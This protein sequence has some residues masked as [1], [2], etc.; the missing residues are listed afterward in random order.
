MTLD[1]SWES[2]TIYFT[3]EKK[4]RLVYFKIF[5]QVRFVE[6]KE[7][8]S[9]FLSSDTISTYSFKCMNHSNSVKICFIYQ[10][11]QDFVFRIRGLCWGVWIGFTI[12]DLLSRGES[13]RHLAF[14]CTACVDVIKGQINTL[15]NGNMNKTLTNH[16]SNLS[17]G[18]PHDPSSLRPCC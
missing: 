3:D 17:F 12:E 10:K 9:A 11:Q 4:D 14:N 16:F 2:Q 8:K 7:I 18:S 5:I 15:E 6:T 13:E 1:T